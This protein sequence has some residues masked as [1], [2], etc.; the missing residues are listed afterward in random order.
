MTKEGFKNFSK[1]KGFTNTKTGRHGRK[2]K[3]T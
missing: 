2:K 3:K 1:K